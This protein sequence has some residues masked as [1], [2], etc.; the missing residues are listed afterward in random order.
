MINK[1]WVPHLIT[2]MALLI[3]GFLGLACATT[4]RPAYKPLASNEE[5]IG[6]VQVSYISTNTTLGAMDQLAY[7]RLLEEAK[8]SYQNN[9]DVRD[10][11]W[12]TVKKVKGYG[13]EWLASGIVILL[14]GSGRN[15]TAG[16]E[17]ALA[18]ASEQTLKNVPAKSKIAIVYI[19]AL[20]KSGLYSRRTGIYLGQ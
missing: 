3:F 11:S 6:T 8:K 20:D 2:V 7:T 10:I 12:V 19:T 4:P 18:R 1:K 5:S 17:G 15:T 16:V 9:I 14:G 13:Y